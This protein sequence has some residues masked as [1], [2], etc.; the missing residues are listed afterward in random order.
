LAASSKGQAL[1]IAMVS[2]RSVADMGGKLGGR[3]EAGQ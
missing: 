2:L 3:G 1:G